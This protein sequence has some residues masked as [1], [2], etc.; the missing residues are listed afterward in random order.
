MHYAKMLCTLVTLVCTK[1]PP[2]F[3]H[4]GHL[5]H[6]ANDIPHWEII[7]H[8]SKFQPSSLMKMLGNIYTLQQH[9]HCTYHKKL[10][11]KMCNDLEHFINENGW[12]CDVW[13]TNV[14]NSTTMYL[15]KQ[16]VKV[17]FIF[18]LLTVVGL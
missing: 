16:V 15:C 9:V 13:V 14:A 6:N 11:L 8:T 2:I 18:N 12:N 17:T 3:Y 7:V 4:E 5:M 10:E 1:S